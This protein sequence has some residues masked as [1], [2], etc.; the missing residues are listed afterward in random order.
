MNYGVFDIEA[1]NW[2]EIYAIGYYSNTKISICKDKLESNNQYI[3]YLLSQIDKPIVYAHN[4][5]AYDFLFIMDYIKDNPK[6]KVSKFVLINGK[7]ISFKIKFN[8]KSITF[9]DSYAILP[10]SLYNLTKS[11]DVK[12]KKLRL[13]YELGIKDNRFNEYFRNDLIGLYEVLI[14]SGL[15]H[16]LTIASNSINIFKNEYYKYGTFSR[17][18][19]KI[20]NFF[21]LAY[22]GGRVELIKTYGEGLYYYDINS[23]YP[24]VMQQ[25]QYPLIQRNNYEL[26]KE[27]IPNICGIYE[28]NVKLDYIYIPLL[29]TTL[30][31]KMIYPYGTFKGYY[32][33]REIEKALKLGYEIEVIKGYTFNNTEYIFKDYVDY[34]YNIKK[35]NEGSKK[36]IAKLLLNSLYGKFG[37]KRNMIKYSINPIKN[38][39]NNEFLTIF[40]NM[41]ISKTKSYN[42]YSNFLHSEISALITANARLKLYELIERAGM[43]NVYYYDTD[44]IITSYQLNTSANLGDIKKV[45]NIDEFIGI[46]AKL[47]AYKNKDGIHITAKGFN[48]SELKYND[49]LDAHKGDLSKIHTSKEVIRKFR[50]S[51]ISHSSNFSEIYKLDR[52]LINQYSK[53]IID[54]NGIDTKPIKV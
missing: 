51:I 31:N 9:K 3:E 48:I 26:T 37:Q 34:Y 42:F 17:N 24:Y 14:E 20:D 45:A 13:D 35:N 22:K 52:T 19:D 12:H 5:G 47:Y 44:S 53:R 28:C 11:F 46:S 2:N 8:G 29:H 33:N 49:F 10:S 40:N 43:N 32:T 54:K 36:E 38:I 23:L 1:Y 4:G 21:R 6:I 41:G 15:T 50:N 30:N 39:K 27:Y 18:S 16:K 7:I 25:Y